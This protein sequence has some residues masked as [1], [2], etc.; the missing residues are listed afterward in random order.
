M[1]QPVTFIFAAKASPGYIRAKNIIRLI[2]AVAD[3]VINQLVAKGQIVNNLLA[4]EPGSVLDAT[5][6]KAL[7]DDITELYSDLAFDFGANAAGLTS[8]NV[9]CRQ[10]GKICFVSGIIVP[11]Q[12]GTPLT[13]ARLSVRPK[14][15]VSFLITGYAKV[16]SFGLLDLDG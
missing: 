5:Q 14:Y 16:A 7:K 2:N 3:Q 10:L 6:G 15:K 1:T 12:A 13:L 9:E 8:A 11:N 4:T